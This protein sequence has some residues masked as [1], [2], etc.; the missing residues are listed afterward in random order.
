[1]SNQTCENT[2]RELWREREGDYYSDSIH[3]TKDGGIGINCGGS[4]FVKSLRGWHELAQASC[5]EPKFPKYPQ[6]PTLGRKRFDKRFRV[7]LKVL[8]DVAREME[9]EGIEVSEFWGS[10]P[11]YKL[12]P[13]SDGLWRWEDLKRF[14]KE[15]I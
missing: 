9:A 8:R 11:K 10:K 2:D 7:M 5:P 1:M 15:G 14:L 6:W 3:V 12:L 4:V 13:T